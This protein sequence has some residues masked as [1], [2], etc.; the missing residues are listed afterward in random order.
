[1]LGGKPSR[2]HCR[3][4]ARWQALTARAAYLAA[5]LALFSACACA[6]PAVDGVPTSTS[7]ARTGSHYFRSNQIALDESAIALIS[8]YAETLRDN[9][10]NWIVLRGHRNDLGSSSYEIALGQQRIDAVRTALLSAGVKPARIRTEIHGDD[11]GVVSACDNDDCRR[12]RQCVD[13]VLNP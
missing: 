8:R 4:E 13:I 7:S 3:Q 5:V 1:M 11:T 9:Q 6:E 12:Q 10:D 2:R